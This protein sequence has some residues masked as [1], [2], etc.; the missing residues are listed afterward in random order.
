VRS[1]N[2]GAFISAERKRRRLT[3]GQLARLVGYRNISKGARRIACLEQ[4]GTA[5]PDLL[6][7]VA[8]ALNLDWAMVERLAEADSQD[9]FRA[10]EEW[11]SQPV[12]MCLVVR[13]MA[14][15]YSRKN[16]P[17]WVTTPEQAEAWACE[18]ARTHRL[19]VCL[20]VSRRLSVWIDGQGEVEARTEA[21][22]DNT[23]APF[24]QV[25]GRRFLLE[26]DERHV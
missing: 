12:P 18:F 3:L 24:M 22:P 15:V 21:V 8:E 5:T 13:L 26:P 6:V 16:L 19:R 17:A 2:L 7:N 9:R 25:K 23:N 14:A 1:S 20:V 10:W 11:A 4:T